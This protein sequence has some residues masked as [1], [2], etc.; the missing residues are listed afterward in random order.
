MGAGLK[1]P[2][3]GGRIACPPDK[4]KINGGIW[5]SGPFGEPKPINKK[6]Y[7][8]EIG[9]GTSTGA[10]AWQPMTG[11]LSC[12]TILKCRRGEIPMRKLVVA[13]CLLMEASTGNAQFIFRQDQVCIGKCSSR[14]VCKEEPMQSIASAGRINWVRENSLLGKLMICDYTGDCLSTILSS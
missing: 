3:F 14:H 12:G 10:G 13:L 9:P 8:I 2:I 7:I 11:G 5:P 4:Y 6:Y 1:F